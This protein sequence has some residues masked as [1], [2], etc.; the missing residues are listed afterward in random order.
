MPK[1][2]PEEKWRWLTSRFVGAIADGSATT[3][4][5]FLD[6]ATGSANIQVGSKLYYG[7]SFNEAMDKAIATFEAYDEEDG[8]GQL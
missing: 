7:S 4:K 3:V 5:L 8:D 2:T 6:G 1:P